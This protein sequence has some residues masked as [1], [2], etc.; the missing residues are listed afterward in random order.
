MNQALAK[1]S[2]DMA[3]NKIDEVKLAKD[4][5]T[6]VLYGARLQGAYADII[7]E[8][9][10]DT[11]NIEEMVENALQSTI[12]NTL[13]TREKRIVTLENGNKKKSLDSHW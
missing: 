5:E 13:E 2:L 6:K 8:H 9:L 3:A 7:T 4:I 12:K 1:I 10:K 11:S